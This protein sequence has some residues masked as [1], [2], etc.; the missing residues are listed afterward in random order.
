[1][2]S[3]ASRLI[4]GHWLQPTA[5]A[6]CNERFEFR[7][8]G[9]LVFSSDAGA[10]AEGVYELAAKPEPSGRYLLQIRMTMFNGGPDC[11]GDTR[12]IEIGKTVTAYMRFDPAQDTL[13]GCSEDSDSS[14]EPAM[15]R[16]R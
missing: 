14:C 5:N 4:L 1:M 7:P 2:S 8:G 15:R 9:A 13:Q 11:D 10:R 12:T 16:I 3:N 6:P